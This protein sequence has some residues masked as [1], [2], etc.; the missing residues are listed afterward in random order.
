M[1]TVFSHRHGRK[2]TTYCLL[3]IQSLSL[4][5]SFFGINLTMERQMLICLLLFMSVCSECF[6]RWEEQSILPAT[7]QRDIWQLERV[8]VLVYVCTASCVFLFFFLFLFSSPDHHYLHQAVLALSVLPLI[9]LS[10]Q[11][12]KIHTWYL[13]SSITARLADR[14]FII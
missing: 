3:L 14:H 9:L 1:K 4:S 7:F 6:V 5:L 8:C 10:S 13:L 2:G 12:N 11:D